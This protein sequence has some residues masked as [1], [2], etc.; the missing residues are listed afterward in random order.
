MRIDHPTSIGEDVDERAC[1]AV[2]AQ[3]LGPIR[4]T[5][6]EVAV[7]TEGEIVRHVERATGSFDEHAKECTR[8]SIVAQDLAAIRATDIEIPSGPSSNLWT[9]Q[10]TAARRNEGVDKVSLAPS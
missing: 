8:R 9:G 3:D 6:V 2:I 10:S 5:H 1:D 4:V 7:I